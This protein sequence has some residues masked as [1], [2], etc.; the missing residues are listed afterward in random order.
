MLQCDV[1]TELLQISL[2]VEKK[3]IAASIDAEL[4]VHLLREALHHGDAQLREL[5]VDC[6][7]ELISNAAGVEAR[8][9]ETEHVAGFEDDYVRAAAL[10]EMIRGAGAHDSAAD[11]NDV[12]ACFHRE[13]VGLAI[14]NDNACSVWSASRQS[15]KPFGVPGSLCLAMR[16]NF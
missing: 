4:L 1:R 3:Q 8:R 9:A 14:A 16:D 2:S 12:G 10:G 7:G 11:D 15:G 5:D 13:A 6:G